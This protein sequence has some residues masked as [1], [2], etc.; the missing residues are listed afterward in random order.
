MYRISMILRYDFNCS[1]L[2]EEIF[3]TSE[4]SGFFTYFS[5]SC[6][7]DP[8]EMLL[9]IITILLLSTWIKSAIVLDLIVLRTQLILA[10]CKLEFLMNF[11][12]ISLFIETITYFLEGPLVV[13]LI[14][15][16]V[17]FFEPLIN[18]YISLIFLLGRLGNI[19]LILSVSLVMFFR[20]AR[21]GC[22]SKE[23]AFVYDFFC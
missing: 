13:M 16:L 8:E 2:D 4:G 23:V 3:S 1:S 17:L 7:S 5:I 12:V 18:F 20:V 6:R 11:F 19:F 15:S 10:M 14:F 22:L 21:L 9:V